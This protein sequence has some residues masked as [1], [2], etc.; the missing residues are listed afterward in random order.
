[1]IDACTHNGKLMRFA[2][3]SVELPGNVFTV[4]VGKNGTGKSRLLNGIVRNYARFHDEFNHKAR[5]YFSY[6]DDP[7]VVHNNWQPS[8]IIAT[9]T[10]PFDRFPVDRYQTRD[11]FY[12]YLGIRGITGTNLSLNFF[13]RTISALIS[14]V[15]R[16]SEHASSVMGALSYLGYYPQIQARFVSELPLRA[17]AE[18]I[19]NPDPLAYLYDFQSSRSTRRPISYSSEISYRSSHE[20]RKTLVRGLEI[21]S[22][23]FKKPRIDITIDR[24][25]AFDSERREFLDYSIASLIEVGIL[26]LHDIGLRKVDDDI[27]FRINEASSGEQCVVMAFL[28]IASHIQ[29]GALICIDEPE[30]CL[31]PEWQERYIG[32]LIS[33]FSRF[34]NCHFVIATHS[35]QIISNLGNYNCYVLDIESGECREGSDLNKRSADFQLAETF[36]SPGYKNEYLTR[37]LIAALGS[38]SKQGVISNEQ[39]KLFDSLLKLYPKINDGDP[40]RRLMDMLK[41]AIG[42]TND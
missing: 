31:H 32:L 13:V 36:S 18:A 38:V 23:S 35:P 20:F 17:I 3:N 11:V 40:V 15:S 5:R 30:V 1:M 39:R 10:S 27:V 22:N 2:G 4:I 14:S 37:E 12:R 34:K 33:T 16:D 6:P 24:N 7:C 29:D 9:S 21:M 41:A 28:G 19:E 25:G 8:V 42:G 26:R